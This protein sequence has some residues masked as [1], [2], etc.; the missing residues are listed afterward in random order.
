MK[1]VFSFVFDIG[2]VLF[3]HHVTVDQEGNEHV[4]FTPLEEGLALLKA[5]H[6]MSQRDGSLVLACTNLKKHE[7]RVLNEHFPEIFA[8]FNGIV[9]PDVALYKK[10][11]LAL[12]HYMLT[13]YDLIPH[14][15]IFFDDMLRN[16]E[17]AR[18]M[19]M[20]GIHIG[21]SRQVQEALKLHIPEFGS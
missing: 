21:D 3:T 17:A 13:A 12:F 16:V 1:K 15:T 8:L 14:H 5:C 20:K 9:S 7:I 18:S 10:P 2:N 6:A 19:G 11:D 4:R